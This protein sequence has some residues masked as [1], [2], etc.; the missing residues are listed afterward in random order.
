M[1]VKGHAVPNG[2]AATASPLADIPAK[3][4]LGFATRAL[5]VG[6]EPELSASSAVIPAIELSTTYSQSR[7][8][9]PHKGFEYTR[10]ANPTRLALERV[11]ASLEGADVLLD[12]NLRRDGKL[13]DW[14]FGPAALAFSS[15]SAATATV[16]S[17]LAGNGGHV[18]SVGD[19][20]GGTSRYMLRV[21]QVQ[22][23]VETTFVDMSYTNKEAL[24]AEETE[25]EKLAREQEDDKVIVK[26][27]QDAIRPNTKL[28]WAETPTNPLLSLVPIRLIAAVA[29]AR[30]IPLVI[31]NTF[32]SPYYQ[33]PLLL[34]ASVVVHS[35]TKYINGH[36]DVLGGTIITA[37][38]VLLEKFRFLQNA[39]G[40][41]PSP[42]DSWLIIRGIK[43]LSLRAR[44][45]GLNGLQ[46]AR[47]LQEVAI[48]A[49]LVRDVFYPGLKRPNETQGQARERSLAWEQ[50]SDQSRKWATS[51]GFS[52]DSEG[53][54]PSG[55][56]VSFHIR[57]E[58]PADQEDAS[59]AE[60]FLE[61]LQV[62]ALAESLGGVESLAELPLK[63]THGG[64]AVE[65]RREL[66]IDGEL[67]RLSVGTEDVE[68]L[69]KDVERA[70]KAAVK[71]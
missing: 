12:E 61:S 57:S 13:D 39:H 58:K 66:G 50:L 4:P 15:G 52:K 22:Q 38:P 33:N 55:G 65:R 63:M 21:A 19:V 23:N 2:T 51:L 30:G 11:L 3:G 64:V 9:V 20:Y 16:V 41:V 7:A 29:K 48:P 59:A 53:G 56:M 40:A 18:V 8:G 6:S 44:Q 5:H 31:D 47:Y 27:V 68:D 10:S 14:E 34:G 71:A 1:T 42:F 26:R 37:D 24:A 36:S 46:I 62:F 25:A 69:L 54:F 43:T 67:V 28:I 70:L 45:H 60:K 32:A 49:G 17:G 35:I